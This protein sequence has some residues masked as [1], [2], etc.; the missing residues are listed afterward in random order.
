MRLPVCLGG[1]EFIK[2][3]PEG[4]VAH[5]CRPVCDHYSGMPKGTK[6]LSR[7]RVRYSAFKLRDVGRMKASGGGEKPLSRARCRCT[8]CEFLLVCPTS[9]VLWF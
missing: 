5:H 1:A 4:L 6:T 2:K 7:R 3:L 8:L 9:V